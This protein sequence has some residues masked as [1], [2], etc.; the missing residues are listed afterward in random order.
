MMN[1]KDCVFCAC[2]LHKIAANSLPFPSGK[3]GHALLQACTNVLAL[4]IL[5]AFF[6]LTFTRAIVFHLS[7]LSIYQHDCHKNEGQ[8]KSLT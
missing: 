1:L 4:K 2:K 3:E 6:Q 8:G 5:C 7:F